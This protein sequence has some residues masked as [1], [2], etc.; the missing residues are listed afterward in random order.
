MRG[1][2]NGETISVILQRIR[3][4]QTQLPNL[5]EFNEYQVILD[6]IFEGHGLFNDLLR[7]TDYSF[8]KRIINYILV[9]KINDNKYLMIVCRIFIE[10]NENE[11]L[12]DLISR[13]GLDKLIEIVYESNLADFSRIIIEKFH[14]SANNQS[15]ISRF[16]QLYLDYIKRVIFMEL[17]NYYK[18]KPEFKEVLKKL[19]SINDLSFIKD[20]SFIEEFFK[21]F[22][23]IYGFKLFDF[24]LENKEQFRNFI[25][26]LKPYIP[27]LFFS[28]RVRN[29]IGLEQT[30]VELFRNV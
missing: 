21:F 11:I 27:S 19:F 18:E 20:L 17:I 24:L 25:Q 4:F 3:E 14:P 6:A 5:T 15:G 9:N 2:E 16:D 1:G 26:V 23:S 30:Q 7:N 22:K 28:S 8:L 13:I 29:I 10:I 12:I